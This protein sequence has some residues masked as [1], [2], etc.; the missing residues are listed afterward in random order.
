ML[1]LD[2]WLKASEVGGLI[3]VT[4]AEAE[5]WCAREEEWKMAGFMTYS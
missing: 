5:A 3:S 4:E 2:S 1:Q